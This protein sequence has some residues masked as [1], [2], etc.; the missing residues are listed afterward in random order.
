MASRST[1]AGRRSC[2]L[3]AALFTG[4]AGA[5]TGCGAPVPAEP[6]GVAPGVFVAVR[7]PRPVYRGASGYVEATADTLQFD[8]AGTVRRTVVL[9]TVSYGGSL[10]GPGSLGPEGTREAASQHA[11]VWHAAGAEVQA[12]FTAPAGGPAGADT[13]RLR[14]GREG[15]LR[16]ATGEQHW[17]RR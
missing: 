6:V 13:L 16:T 7:V 1:R 15:D 3:A 8:A 17:V 9:R 12:I 10:A 11:G 14:V 4:A 5:L 2:S